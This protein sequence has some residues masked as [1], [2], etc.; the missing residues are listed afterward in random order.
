MFSSELRGMLDSATTSSRHARFTWKRALNPGSSKQGKARRASFGSKVVE[1]SHLQHA[2]YTCTNI[3][4]VAQFC[5]KNLTKSVA[6]EPEGSSPHSRTFPR[7]FPP[8]PCTLFSPLP[9]MP[10][11]PPTS[12]ALTWPA[13][14]LKKCKKSAYA[15]YCSKTP[16]WRTM[17]G[18]GTL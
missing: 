3:W 14:L 5:R 15:A 9:C 4:S 17:S 12:F 16:R 18:K 6:Q 11:D 8:K 7:A 10:H 2:M 13:N 1:A